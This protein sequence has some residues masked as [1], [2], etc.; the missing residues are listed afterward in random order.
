MPKDNFVFW[1]GMNIEYT[2]DILKSLAEVLNIKP[3][4]LYIPNQ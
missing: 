1:V 2:V 3:L 4:F